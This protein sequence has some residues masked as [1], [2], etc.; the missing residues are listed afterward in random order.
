ME[1]SSEYQSIPGLLVD[2]LVGPSSGTRVRRR[3]RNIFDVDRLLSHGD[4]ID[5]KY[6]F[7]VQ[8]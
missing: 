8:Y 5:Q 6:F 1:G 4:A 7:I 3:H 2:G